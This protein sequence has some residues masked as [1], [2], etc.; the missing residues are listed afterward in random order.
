MKQNRHCFESHP[1]F[2]LCWNIAS[3]LK[4]W[5]LRAMIFPLIARRR[6]KHLRLNC[7]RLM[8]LRR[9]DFVIFSV[10]VEPPRAY[11]LRVQISCVLCICMFI[12]FCSIRAHIRRRR[13]KIKRP[14]GPH[15]RIRVRSKPSRAAA[16][17]HHHYNIYISHSRV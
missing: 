7:F 13:R 11:T 5:V 1:T 17:S 3:C 8:L 15:P 14:R 12:F 9:A 10:A 2:S 16:V 4:L 6:F